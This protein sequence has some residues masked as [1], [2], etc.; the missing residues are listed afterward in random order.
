MAEK[1]IWI[2]GKPQTPRLTILKQPDGKFTVTYAKSDPLNVRGKMDGDLNSEL[3]RLFGYES[4]EEYK[5]E[6]KDDLDSKTKPITRDPETNAVTQA[7]TVH[8]I[9]VA[10]GLEEF[11]ENFDVNQYEI[12]G[13]PPKG[14]LS[15]VQKGK[16]KEAVEKL[17][18]AAK[19]REV[20]GY[21]PARAGFEPAKKHYDLY[22]VAIKK[23]DFSEAAKHIEEAYKKLETV[24][25]KEGGFGPNSG[26]VI[27][28]GMLGEWAEALWLAGDIDR[29]AEIF[30]KVLE[31]KH[32]SK[33]D[34]KHA[35]RVIEDLLPKLANVASGEAILKNVFKNPILPD[36]SKIGKRNIRS[37]NNP[38]ELE[39]RLEESISYES[40]TFE[41]LLEH[42]LGKNYLLE[43]KRGGEGVGLL[44]KKIFDTGKGEVDKAIKAG[45]P[46]AAARAAK[47]ARGADEIL[48]RVAQQ[49]TFRGK[50][51][52]D[53]ERQYARK[54][55]D[56]LKR[57]RRGK[58]DE[59]ATDAISKVS[60]SGDDVAGLPGPKAAPGLP[61]PKADALGLPG[62]KGG[63]SAA[64]SRI[65]KKALAA[66]GV[67]AGSSLISGDTAAPG[68]VA[69]GQDN[70]P[71]S[72]ADASTTPSEIVAANNAAILDSNSSAIRSIVD[73]RK[74]F[75][76]DLNSENKKAK[77]GILN[78]AMYFP[79]EKL[80][81]KNAIKRIKKQHGNFEEIFAQKFTEPMSV[82]H[83]AGGY[84]KSD[85]K[86]Y[87]DVTSDIAGSI[88][89][90][91]KLAL[92]NSQMLKE[93]RTL[94]EYYGDALAMDPET[95]PENWS[96]HSIIQNVGPA[97]D[98]VGDWWRGFG[99]WE[100]DPWW[101]IGIKLVVD[102]FDPTGITAWPAVEDAK[103]TLDDYTEKLENCGD[104]EEKCAMAS[105]EVL[106]AQAWYYTN[107]AQAIPLVGKFFK[108]AKLK[109][110]LATSE[111]M[112]KA[113]KVSKAEVDKI[114][115]ELKEI[116]ESGIT[117]IDKVAPSLIKVSRA[118]EQMAPV[119]RFKAAKE[120]RKLAKNADPVSARAMMS[121]ARKLEDDIRKA[122]KMNWR[123]ILD[124]GGAGAGR[125]RRFVRYS[126]E[127]AVFGAV[128]AKIGFDYDLFGIDITAGLSKDS[129]G[130]EKTSRSEEE[131]EAMLNPSNFSDLADIPMETVDLTYYILPKGWEGSNWLTPNEIVLSQR[132]GAS[133]NFKIDAP[134][135]TILSEKPPEKEKEYKASE[136]RF[137]PRA[138]GGDYDTSTMNALVFGHSQTGR[139]ARSLREK[140][141]AGGG[142][143]TVKSFGGGSD[144]NLAKE[145][146]NITGEFSHAF[147]FLGGN[148]DPSKGKQYLESKKE[149]IDH[150]KNVLDVD[151]SNIIVTLPPV[152]LA[153]R[154]DYTEKDAIAILGRFTGYVRP[155][156]AGAMHS[157]SVGPS[158]DGAIRDTREQYNARVQKRLAN[159]KS[160]ADYSAAR[161]K[162]NSIARDFFNRAGVKTAPPINSVDKTDFKDG[163]HMS[164]SGALA[165]KAS[166]ILLSSFIEPD[167]EDSKELKKKIDK[168]VPVAGF[169]KF[170]KTKG[171]DDRK[172]L[173]RIIAEEAIK[174]G[175][176]P[177]FVLNKARVEGFNPNSV[178]KKKRYR[179]GHPKQGQ[180]I[181]GQVEGV[182]YG[183]GSSR[184]FH[185]VFQFKGTRKYQ[186]YWNE[187]FGLDWSRVYDPRH[188]AET[189]MKVVKKKK[190]QLRSAGLPKDDY[191]L[192]LSWQQGTDGLKQIHRA[193]KENRELTGDGLVGWKNKNAAWRDDHAARI[194]R[195]MKNNFYPQYGMSGSSTNPKN[196]LKQWNKK[197]Q[198]YLRSSEKE[199]SEVLEQAK[200]QPISESLFLKQI[201]NIIE[202][203]KNNELV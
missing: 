26:R 139:F 28:S 162:M 14:F 144:E 112:I 114:A 38:G 44:L 53:T 2:S 107:I 116:G 15:G 140:V 49:G 154:S 199:F 27:A 94:K 29:S 178:P 188:Q 79:Q 81:N 145:I 113:K 169:E 137:D 106:K 65:N 108:L 54:L 149:I 85:F 31:S 70:E 98:E 17:A 201:F 101:K 104:D 135:P 95:K 83:P 99:D 156:S 163:Y 105:L 90:D 173:A 109:K 77:L 179:K 43:S 4:W 92:S 168:E 110:I 195:N 64:G 136:D 39:P 84:W 19:D 50:K 73:M 194:Q 13:L 35:R 100:E 138:G 93:N 21:N 142:S 161:T 24:T 184:G 36:Y 196:F 115:K 181:P 76:G 203:T 176:D 46:D 40:M 189:F 160:M 134:A 47:A 202:E 20:S 5:K 129:E 22:R 167:T 91:P 12:I 155:S 172:S 80:M 55:L 159:I 11:V 67:I 153:L 177:L 3:K 120:L 52:S 185:G 128:V 41:D 25:D 34:K 186:K 97:L 96:K 71:I 45:G 60:K 119:H 62:P 18:Q 197:Y 69:P 190:R 87:K 30:K 16:E 171:S 56:D 164:A 10:Y 125:L 66:A 1:N 192:Y 89:I 157:K 148:A 127:A 200:S 187:E 57:V 146:K 147:L 6:N 133:T 51:L 123:E 198:S 74:K 9:H 150:V 166:D 183:K 88:S 75:F 193:A 68:A 32:T 158:S 151:P 78:L 132:V 143:V 8:P 61:G 7:P 174:A 72:G 86:N 82:R 42:V 58:Y 175:E 191:L 111:G 131:K 170:D 126:A 124:I 180:V 59:P 103:A 102:I 122:A 48:K 117:Q 23:E 141:K 165:K 37:V 33:E 63:P 121:T 118:G 130:P 182:D 152:N